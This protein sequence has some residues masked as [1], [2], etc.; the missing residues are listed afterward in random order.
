MCIILNQCFTC[1]EYNGVYTNDCT[2]RQYMRVKLVCLCQQLVY[3]RI[4]FVNKAFYLSQCI[5]ISLALFRG[6]RAYTE[7]LYINIQHTQS[8]YIMRYNTNH[9][10][11]NILIINDKNHYIF[12]GNIFY[13]TKCRTCMGD[14]LYK[15]KKVIHINSFIQ[16]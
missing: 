2:Y 11:Y 1:I 6:K 10:G 9:R 12:K 16:L 5:Y 7:H 15:L 13:V 14:L 8:T 3:V 4:Q